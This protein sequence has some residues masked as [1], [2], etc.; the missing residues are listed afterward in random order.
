M[1]KEYLAYG[2]GFSDA[3]SQARVRQD[4]SHSIPALE[5]AICSDSWRRLI[6]PANWMP[7][8]SQLTSHGN[9][10]C[11]VVQRKSV[12]IGGHLALRYSSLAARVET[13]A[14][15]SRHVLR[16]KSTKHWKTLAC[17][18]IGNVRDSN[19]EFVMAAEALLDLAYH[20][21]RDSVA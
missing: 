11:L 16:C 3:G 17:E 9:D 6:H 12:P 14:V 20:V 2:C 18:R 7:P 10:H 13:K 19:T 4:L 15:S 21:K 1:R 8:F 5:L